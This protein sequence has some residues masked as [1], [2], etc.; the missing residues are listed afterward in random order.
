[1]KAGIH[2]GILVLCVLGA[3]AVVLTCGGGGGGTSD[4]AV[5]EEHDG[6]E[7]TA[8]MEKAQKA[9][10]ENDVGGFYAL[11]RNPADG[12][13]VWDRM[14]K[15]K[16]KSGDYHVTRLTAHP[17]LERA[18]PGLHVARLMVH[19]WFDLSR[20]TGKRGDVYETTWSFV[21]ADSVW[22]LWNIRID[23]ASISYHALLRD[24]QRMSYQEYLTLAMDWEEFVDPVPLMQRWLEAA[25]SEDFPAL[26][27]RMVAGVYPRAF[28]MNIELPTLASDD[29]W[30]GKSNRRSAE[31]VM[32][33]DINT[34]RS[35]ASKLGSELD[36]LTLYFGAYSVTSMPKDCTK[37]KMYINYDGGRLPKQSIT[38]FSVEWSCSYI[39]SRWLIESMQVKSITYRQ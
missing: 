9:I 11:F 12:K 2:G 15:M 26:E 29:D 20:E 3:A 10:Q 38:D 13:T 17:G 8:L 31:N 6:A 16:W 4:E 18:E 1:M 33:K 14:D 7:L 35:S 32:E 25:A 23:P 37:L 22:K 27:S 21:R 34:L 28:E 39:N 24:M 5:V 36:E 19:A 30:A